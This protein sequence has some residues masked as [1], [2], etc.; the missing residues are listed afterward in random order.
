MKRL[1]QEQKDEIVQKYKSGE[2]VEGLLG[3]FGV[4]KNSIYRWIN[5]SKKKEVE[6]AQIKDWLDA[7][8]V[9]KGIFYGCKTKEVENT[10]SELSGYGVNERGRKLGKGSNPLGDRAQ[11]FEPKYEAVDGKVLVNG[12]TVQL[13]GNRLKFNTKYLP[14]EENTRVNENEIK[15]GS[16]GVPVDNTISIDDSLAGRNSK[17][18]VICNDILKKRKYTKWEKKVIRTVWS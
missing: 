1:T 16:G 18:F 8:P 10:S 12:E 11:F 9:Y 3:Y 17:F 7:N 13:E 4:S 2:S 5:E 15:L 6:E 14:S